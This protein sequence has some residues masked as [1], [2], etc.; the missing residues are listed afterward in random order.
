MP[1]VREFGSGTSASR[2]TLNLRSSSQPLF[3]HT[4]LA[5]KSHLFWQP[6]F[7]SS[8]E[9]DYLFSNLQFSSYSWIEF[10]SFYILD[11]IN[12]TYHIRFSYLTFSQPLTLNTS[13]NP[14]PPYHSTMLYALSNWSRSNHERRRRIRSVRLSRHCPHNRV[15]QPQ[16]V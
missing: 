4:R 1:R 14:L 9:I 3:L 11:G 6:F 16:P 12:V 13:T 7:F 10:P 8:I 5:Y 15:K 2:S